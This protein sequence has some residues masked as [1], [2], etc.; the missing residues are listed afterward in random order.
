MQ[1]NREIAKAK[2][3]C[4]SAAAFLSLSISSLSHTKH[5]TFI[6]HLFNFF[7]LSIA[8]PLSYA[9]CSSALLKAKQCVA[10]NM[11][12]PLRRQILLRWNVRPCTWSFASD[13]GADGFCFSLTDCAYAKDFKF[14][15]G[16][17]LQYHATLPSLNVTNGYFVSTSHQCLKLENFRFY[18][19]WVLLCVV[20]LLELMVSM[21]LRDWVISR[22]RNFKKWM[23]FMLFLLLSFTVGASIYISLADELESSLLLPMFAV[24]VIQI[25]LLHV[26]TT[27]LDLVRQRRWWTI[28]AAFVDLFTVYLLQL[29]PAALASQFA[30]QTEIQKSSSISCQ[31]HR[32]HNAVEHSNV[33]PYEWSQNNNR[34]NH[35]PNNDIALNVYHALNNYHALINNNHA[36]NNDHALNNNHAAN[37]THALI[38][39]LAPNINHA[40]H[41]INTSGNWWVELWNAII[42]TVMLVFVVLSYRCND[43]Q[44]AN[45]TAHM[46]H[47]LRKG[48][49]KVG[50]RCR[51]CEPSAHAVPAIGRCR[52]AFVEFDQ[53]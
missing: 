27:L 37:N 48:N 6:R 44:G 43:W 42:R 34:N 49:C 10:S 16:K 45:S 50:L 12:R 38:N 28:P 7:S 40:F 29:C 13:V 22:A 17:E 5:F 35:A 8:H 20:F 14:S 23:H 2:V 47:A 4:M 18:S 11:C 3:P 26:S 1:V 39:N 32:G 36:V 46:V 52:D 41:N 51:I 21:Y 25:D 31:R 15:D 53:S 33:L 30:C 9:L 24:I 19:F